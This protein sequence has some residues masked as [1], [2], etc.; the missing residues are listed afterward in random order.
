MRWTQVQEWFFTL[1]TQE[2]A[3]FLVVALFTGFVT[4]LFDVFRRVRERRR[5][6]LGLATEQVVVQL[7]ALFNNNGKNTLILRNA[8]GGG[9]LTRVL[10]GSPAAI[11]LILDLVKKTTIKNP[12]LEFSGH[13]GE[14]ALHL[15]INSV[16]NAN[17]GSS[18][19]L[20]TVVVAVTCE[21]RKWVK[22]ETLRV[23]LITSQDL[24]RFE[25]LNF[26]LRLSVEKPWQSLRILCLRQI[27]FRY[28][29]QSAQIGMPGSGKIPLLRVIQIGVPSGYEPVD[30]QQVNWSGEFEKDFLEAAGLGEEW[31]GRLSEIREA[32]EK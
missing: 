27:A 10:E 3:A 2:I 15:L 22:R 9:P 11:K 16:I 25:D 26:C 12:L 6:R 19:P 29:N 13:D 28:K 20:R 17:A 4:R 5:L 31:L 1:T 21:D 18:H 7:N 8:S 30:S 32:K 14:H 23:L 24:K